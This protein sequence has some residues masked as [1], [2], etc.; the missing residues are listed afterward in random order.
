MNYCRTNFSLIASSKKLITLEKKVGWYKYRFLVSIVSGVASYGTLGHVPPSTSNNFIFSLLCSKPESQ[1]SQQLTALSISTALVTK[2]FISHEAAA[3]PGP[4]VRRECPMS[5]FTALPLLATNP[6]DATV[7]CLCQLPFVSN[8]SGVFTRSNVS[9][10]DSCQQMTQKLL[11]DFVRQT[12][13]ALRK[14]FSIIHLYSITQRLQYIEAPRW[15]H[16]KHVQGVAA[17]KSEKSVEWES[18]TDPTRRSPA[19]QRSWCYNLIN[20]IEN[21]CTH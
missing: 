12:V 8:L 4:E 7:H 18:K 1:L 14:Q 5:K 16:V 21:R 3:A 10:K 6:G 13:A 11:L 15:F 2:L 19:C 9:Q 17:V 20:Q